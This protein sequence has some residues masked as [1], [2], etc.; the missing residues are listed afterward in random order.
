MTSITDSF[1]Q[2]SA[3]FLTARYEIPYP[4]DN[5]KIQVKDADRTPVAENTCL[6]LLYSLQFAEMAEL[7]C[8]FWFREKNH[9]NN[10]N[11]LY[12]QDNEGL[13]RWE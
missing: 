8:L 12:H 1:E 2:N 5:D 6:F 9:L 11:V 3:L 7:T 10:V 4:A 13:L